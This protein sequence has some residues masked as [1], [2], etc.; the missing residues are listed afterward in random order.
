MRR[1]LV[2][3]AG[4][5]GTMVANLARRRLDPGHWQVTVVDRDDAHRYQPGY[6]F[7]PF[8]TYRPADVVRPRSHLL[9]P[10]VELILGEVDR[11][12]PAER[13]VRLADG[14]LLD[15]DLLVIATGIEPRPELTPGLLG[16]QWRQSIYDFYTYD[17]AVALGGMLPGWPGGRLV[18]DVAELP[19][20]CP[21]A[22][23][24]FAFL[25]DAFFADRGMR[26]RVDLTYVTPLPEAFERPVAARH[27]G[28]MLRERRIALV[29]D[30]ALARVDDGRLVAADGR[31]LSFDLL[32]SIPPARGAQYLAR[33]GLGDDRNL[34]PVDRGTLQSLAHA[35]VFAIGDTTDVP[36]PRAGS[37]AAYALE[38]FVD[39]LV[40][41][42]AGLAPVSRFDGHASCFVEAGHGK[43]VLLDLDYGHEPLPRRYPSARLGPFHV[44]RETR[45]N[46]LGHRALR[47]LYWRAFLQGR[48]LP[49]TGRHRSG[50]APADDRDT[51]PTAT[52][53]PPRQR[54]P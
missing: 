52:P 20:T 46:H 1:L 14:R 16:P 33:S 47:P 51:H 24:A 27:L 40:R 5:S 44:L 13:T 49:L 18:V 32:V 21:V 54:R 45:A 3:G 26:S 11:V 39:N 36:T 15:Y 41:R 10:A 17:G 48:A 23:L 25:A 37:V 30:F 4:A 9:H 8:G 35:D 42:C 7:L 28:A 43:A 12:D 50:R 6:L 34:V 31:T 38:G 19:I 22:P 53:P 29:P 2:L